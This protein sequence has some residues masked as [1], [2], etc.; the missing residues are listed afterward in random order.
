M[1]PPTDGL[2]RLGA[3]FARLR[4]L[5]GLS[6]AAL[7]DRIGLSQASISRF[8]SG[9]QPGL[10]ARWLGLMLIALR[11]GAG[12]LERTLERRP[13]DDPDRPPWS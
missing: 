3:T 9:K 4:A 7:G 8:E 2:E 10:A 13:A 11:V 6:Q 12:E 1:P 5:R